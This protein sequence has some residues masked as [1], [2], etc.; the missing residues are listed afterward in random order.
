ML[1]DELKEKKK[2]CTGCSACYTVC[3]V[4]AIQM[5]PDEEGFFKPHIDMEKCIQCKLCEKTCP[6]INL[7]K[8]NYE[9]PRC[10]A[11]RAND[12]ILSV[13]SS[14]GA[15]SVLAD[16]VFERGGYV[17]GAAYD[18][19]FKG[20]SHIMISEKSEMYRLRGSKYVYSKPGDIYRQVL[21][22]L[23][24]NKYVL[25]S[26][27]PCQVAALKKVLK[28]DYEKLITVD[29]LCGGVPS[30]RVF[31]EYIDEISE[32]KKILSVNFRP[33]EFGWQYS[34]IQTIFEDNSIHMVHSVRDSYLKGFLNWLYVGKPCEN[35]EYAE[36]G[37][38]GDFSIGDFWNIDKFS[39]IPQFTDG[40]SC[41]LLNN[42]RAEVIYMKLK[43]KFCFK[44]EVL[45]AFLKRFNRMQR[46][47]DS[48]LARTRFFALFN[49]GISFPK[50][51]DYSL[52]W[53]FDVALTGMWTV[54]N[55][56]GELTYYALYKTLIQMGYTTIMVERRKD[57]PNY[58]VPNPTL[59]QENPY[60][61]YDISKIHKTTQEQ[62]ELNARV[63]NFIIGSDQVWNHRIIESESVKS[64][65]LDYTADWRKRISYATSFGSV[66]FTGN[67]EEK[68]VFKNLIQRFDY[69]S[70]REKS[71]VSLCK[72]DFDVK[73]EWVVDPVFL[74]DKN[75]FDHLAEKSKCCISGN[76]IFTYFVH[77]NKN[78][79]GID[80][81]ARKMNYGLI[82]TINADGYN[83][84][85]ENWPYTYE[86]NCKVES[87]L[88]YLINS[89]FIITDSFH[90]TCMA[91]IYRIPFVFI[92]GTMNEQHGFERVSTIL[93]QCGLMDRV[94]SNVE[95]ALNRKDLNEKIDFD[96]VF[97]KLNP[98]IERSRKWLKDAIEADKVVK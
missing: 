32:G 91:L 4:G 25:F 77:P 64:Y 20:V 97:I 49:E 75:V 24:K 43:D 45:L 60:P 7:E 26:G 48:H 87:W 74:C 10:Y 54:R 70:V 86:K 65:T 2:E 42:K 88:Y 94:A 29:I 95:E 55:Y 90:A 39:N 93:G 62:K 41:L 15:F 36:P 71:G 63:K 1:I 44:H 51:V 76:Y 17:C 59:F 22:K 72:K 79:F 14:G 85:G 58:N 21:E 78:H 23:K 11:V 28:K 56:G 8:E 89:K 92:R 83:F 46:H 82:N 34:G 6:Q 19:D 84:T 9:N 16:Y 27:T 33:K 68:E 3:P 37:R 31:R 98:E 96:K 73:A 38:Q 81:Y 13:S 69:I 66:E 67:E 61:F 53:K 18:E 57:L 35:C 12:D 40:V 47:R 80:K 50:C 52:N 5:Q 30:E